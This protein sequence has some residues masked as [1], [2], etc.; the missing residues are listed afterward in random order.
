[1][2]LPWQKNFQKK[3]NEDTNSSDLSAS[4]QKAIDSSLRNSTH[5][6]NGQGKL[7][8]MTSPKKLLKTSNI[9]YGGG[10]VKKQKE[11][12]QKST[13]QSI[14]SNHSRNNSQ[15][16]INTFKNSQVNN[17]VSQSHVTEDNSITGAA[18][19]NHHQKVHCKPYKIFKI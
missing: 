8:Q 1:M 13:N 9:K 5:S 12:L 15:N 4:K 17:D 18:M 16:I 11:G 2:A 6:K 3:S 10:I 19:N 14:S 7:F